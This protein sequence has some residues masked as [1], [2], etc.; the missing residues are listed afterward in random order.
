MEQPEGNQDSGGGRP[1]ENNR[2]GNNADQPTPD[3]ARSSETEQS[4]RHQNAE[5]CNR[6]NANGCRNK[7]WDAAKTT[8]ELFLGIGLLTVAYWQYTVYDRQA[9]IMQ[10]LADISA[11][12]L[13][14]TQLESRAWVGPLN[15][16]IQPS[17]TGQPPTLEVGKGIPVSV[18]YINTG[19]E[20][21][22]D[23]ALS[24]SDNIFTID[25]WKSDEIAASVKRWER[26]CLAAPLPG[27]V[28][29]VVFP[30]TNP[31]NSFSYSTTQ[32]DREAAAGKWP[33]TSG[34]LSGDEV[35][36]VLGCMMYKSAGTVHHTSF[37]NFYQA[38]ASKL[39][40]FSVCTIGN[41]AN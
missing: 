17:E 25:Q 32:E 38:K 21:A 7:F 15:V 18:Q 2:A 8:A 34:L 14:A 30:T 29:S 13:T 16:S 6:P 20:P 4:G 37:C 28:G 33:V 27:I 26:E 39:T 23:F 24:H 36:V 40:A 9:G 31:Y 12:Q 10:T 11:K 35:F 41:D 1:A 3:A 19:K 5:C 22:T